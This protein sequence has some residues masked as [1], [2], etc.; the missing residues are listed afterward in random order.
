MW[1]NTSL[2]T[3]PNIWKFIG[4]LKTEESSSYL[5]FI[6]INNRSFKKKNRKNKDVQKDLKIQTAKFN[7]VFKNLDFKEYLIKVSQVVQDFEAGSKKK[8]NS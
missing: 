2:Q 4:K 8:K 3:H 1:L 5:K 7:L 6:R